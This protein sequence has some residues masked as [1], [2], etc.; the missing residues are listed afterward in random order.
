LKECKYKMLFHPPQRIHS[1][2]LCLNL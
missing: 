2:N 1:K